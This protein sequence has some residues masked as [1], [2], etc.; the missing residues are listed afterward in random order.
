MPIRL[1]T[2]LIVLG[3][4]VLSGE[5]SSPKED[6]GFVVFR[7]NCIACHLQTGMGIREMNAPSIAGLPRWYV[8]DQLRKFRRDQRGF[9]E[10][11]E[12]GILMQANAIVLDEKS[13]AF[14]GRYIENLAPNDQR[15]TLD[16]QISKT[17]KT[18]YL[19]N[20]ANCHGDDAEGKRT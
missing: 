19:N 11:D 6:L 3:T 10:E 8:S 18:L 12:S 14:V 7:D 9:H 17:A 1:L 15:N 13:I 4:V 16:I 2:V 5:D 20:C